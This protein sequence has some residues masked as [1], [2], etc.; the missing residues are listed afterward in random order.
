MHHHPD[1]VAD[2][3]QITMVVE[4]RGDRRCIG[5]QTDDG[6][7]TLAGGNIRRGQ[8]TDRVLTVRGQIRTPGSPG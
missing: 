4:D 8:P 7:T 3:Q 5:C 2:Q 1:A 6:V